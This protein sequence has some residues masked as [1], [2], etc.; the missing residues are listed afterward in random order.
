MDSLIL[1]ICFVVILITAIYRRYEKNKDKKLLE[2]IHELE[3]LKSN[4]N[5]L[6]KEK[7][8]QTKKN[9]DG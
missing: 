8:Q 4:L 1:T 3:E 7:T 5:E 2:F 9:C 6:Q